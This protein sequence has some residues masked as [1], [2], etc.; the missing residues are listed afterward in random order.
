MIHFLFS[1]KR[2]DA[3]RKLNDLIITLQ[4]DLTKLRENLKEKLRNVRKTHKTVTFTFT[5]GKFTPGKVIYKQ[6]KRANVQMVCSECGI[7]ETYNGK[8]LR[9]QV[10]HI[11]GDNKNNEISNLTL[12]CP[13]CHSQTDSYCGKNKKRPTKFCECG[14]KIQQTSTKCRPCN[15]KLRREL[16]NENLKKQKQITPR[17]LKF[18]V[19]KE[20]LE[21]LVKTTPM[22]KIGEM[23]GVSDN[24]IKKRCKKLGIHIDNRRGY[25]RKIATGNL[26]L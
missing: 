9:L 25:W 5:K 7:G 18:E 23:F 12:L 17:K 24:A 16:S 2:S 21:I 3:R 14:S 20:E 10:H 15:D 19:D 26:I 1:Y 4:I 22:T 6:L 11:D 13:N 8:F